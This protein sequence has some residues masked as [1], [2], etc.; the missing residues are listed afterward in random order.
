MNHNKSIFIVG[1][2]IL[3]PFLFNSCSESDSDVSGCTDS[4]AC[5]YNSEATVSDGSCNFI[6]LTDTE[7]SRV[8]SFVETAVT[9]IDNYGQDSAF[10][11]FEDT[12]GAFID[13]ELYIFVWDSTA[14]VL[15]HGFQPNLIGTNVYNL[16][17]NHGKYFVQELMSIALGSEGKGWG[18][19]YWDDP[20]TQT[21]RKK[22]TY[23]QLHNGIVVASGTYK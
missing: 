23:V 22:F 6:C 11:S 1:S 12:S 2:L 10:T 16:Q 18:W 3:L 21:I 17:D 4:H 7:K 5:N 15:S 14:T 9:F 20:I 13:D 8:I 19:Y